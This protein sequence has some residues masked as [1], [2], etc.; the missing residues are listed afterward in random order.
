MGI[1]P[2]IYRPDMFRPK[3][4]LESL[5]LLRPQSVPWVSVFWSTWAWV[6][7]AW[8]PR[9]YTVY[10]Y[11]L[12]IGLQHINGI[13]LH[14]VYIYILQV[15]Y[16][17]IY[18]YILLVGGWAVPMYMCTVYIYIHISM[19][20]MDNPCI[21]YW[22]VLEPSLWK[23]MEFVSWD[24]DIPNIWKNKKCSKPPTRL[25][26]VFMSICRYNITYLV[27][28]WCIPRMIGI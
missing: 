9:L 10:I 14:L 2:E 17:Y 8:N 28:I 11:I 4:F 16:I 27:I 5:H 21:Y 15:V 1:F 18:I 12:L 20:N 25:L 22:L 6:A 3:L 13:I 19:Y 26:C 24:D 23:M 7:S